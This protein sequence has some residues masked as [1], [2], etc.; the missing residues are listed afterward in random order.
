MPYSPSNR[1]LR[2]EYDIALENH[3]TGFMPPVVHDPILDALR[4][5]QMHW[6]VK[7]KDQVENV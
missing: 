2:D 6:I 3:K 7:L 5:M 4:G 1:L